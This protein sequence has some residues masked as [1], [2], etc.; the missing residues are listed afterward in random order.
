M[1]KY[2]RLEE[3]GAGS[4]I[5]NYFQTLVLKTRYLVDAE[6]VQKPH[7]PLEY[8]EPYY[9]YCGTMKTSQ[10]EITELSRMHWKSLTSFPPSVRG[11]KA[12]SKWK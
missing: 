4:V 2:A 7:K 12:R 8:H 9:R 10:V 11:L 1:N 3:A 5:K 6:G